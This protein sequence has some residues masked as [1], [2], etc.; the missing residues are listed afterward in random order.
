M[1]ELPIVVGG[2]VVYPMSFEIVLVQRLMFKNG[3][4]AD[5]FVHICSTHNLVVMGDQVGDAGHGPY[6]V[7]LFHDQKIQFLGY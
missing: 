6:K 1:V 7:W 4:K 2:A 3:T 5:L